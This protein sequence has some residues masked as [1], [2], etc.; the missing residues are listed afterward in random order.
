MRFSSNIVGIG[1]S[2]I[3]TENVTVQGAHWR[4]MS[5]YVNSS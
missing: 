5:W 4:K 3:H 1:Q 2:V